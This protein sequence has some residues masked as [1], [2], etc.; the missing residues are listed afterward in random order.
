MRSPLMAYCARSGFFSLLNTAVID[1]APRY[2]AVISSTEI[3]SEVAAASFIRYFK[4][5]HLVLINLSETSADKMADLV[6]HGKVG[7]VLSQIKI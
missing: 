4:G 7:E 3:K 1:G 6:I 5:N 2:T